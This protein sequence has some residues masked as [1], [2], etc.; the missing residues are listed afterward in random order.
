MKRTAIIS[1]H[2]TGE[3]LDNLKKLDIRPV[4]IPETPDVAG[5]LSGHPDL[6][7]FIYKRRCFCHPDIST[8][9]LRE[10]EDSVEIVIC[11][12]GLSPEHPADIPYNIASA[13]NIAMHKLQF[14]ERRI[15]ENLEKSGVEF[16]DVSQPYTKCSTLVAGEKHIITSDTSVDKAAR[17]A[18]LDSLLI[19]PGHVRLPGYR[20]GF[21]GGASGNTDEHVLLTGSISKHPHRERIEEFIWGTGKSIYY[22]SHEEILD[23]GTVFVIEGESFCTV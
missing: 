22:L 9:F 16:Y 14:T 15:R 12:T 20:Y 17:S 6:Q 19:S 5:P 3:M 7:L 23:L 4:K 10:I 18:G 11:E 13:G 2:A 21:I 8:A 1:P